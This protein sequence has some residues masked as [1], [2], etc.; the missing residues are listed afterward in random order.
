LHEPDD[1]NR[2]RHHDKHAHEQ[3]E[4]RAMFS[5]D[6]IGSLAEDRHERVLP[7][8]CGVAV[9]VGQSSFASSQNRLSSA[10]VKRLRK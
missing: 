9:Q 8:V 4:F 10:A 2:G 3:Q 7:E 6:G 1:D 5:A